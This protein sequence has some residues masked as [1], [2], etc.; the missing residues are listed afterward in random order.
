[1]VVQG[2]PAQLV[3]LKLRHGTATLEDTQP[4][5]Q[6]RGP[7]TVARAR[8]LYLVVNADFTTSQ[9]PFTVAGLPR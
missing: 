5:D 3:F 6:L 7:S 1:V 9:R 8:G 4:S 2:N